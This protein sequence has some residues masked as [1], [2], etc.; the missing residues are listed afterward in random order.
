MKPPKK[1]QFSVPP[2][3]SFKMK[4]D[5]SRVIAEVVDLEGLREAI[6]KAPAESIIFHTRDGNDFAAWIREVVH[7]TTL[8][9]V[10]EEI[11]AGSGD[12]ESTRLRMLTVLDLAIEMA[13]EA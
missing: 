4:S 10:M 3:R 8:S 2:E 11:R 9:Q 12:I 13:K 6:E 5:H 7:H 1:F